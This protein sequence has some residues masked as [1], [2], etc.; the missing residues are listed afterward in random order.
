MIDEHAKDLLE[1]FARRLIFG[2][3]R[4]QD[5]LPCEIA[6]HTFDE[7]RWQDLVGLC[8]RAAEATVG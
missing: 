3:S 2:I 5:R 8:R 1:H 7:G 4:E 6:A